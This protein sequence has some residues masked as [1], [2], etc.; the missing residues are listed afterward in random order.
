MQKTMKHKMEKEEYKEEY[1]KR[2]SVEGPFGI[3]K[4]Q[5]HIEKK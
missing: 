1:V 2:S 4:Q 3:L 5:Y